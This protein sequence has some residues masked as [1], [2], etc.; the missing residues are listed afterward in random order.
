VGIGYYTGANKRFN[1][2]RHQTKNQQII[3]F[4]FHTLKKKAADSRH[5][6]EWLPAIF[7]PGPTC[8][9][10]TCALKDTFVKK[11]LFIYIF[12]FTRAREKNRSTTV[13]CDVL[14]L[15]SE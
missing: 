5:C 14:S 15:F 13:W 10:S 9:S 1:S 12:F 3:L 6:R 11:K 2:S 7:A 4:P 8:S